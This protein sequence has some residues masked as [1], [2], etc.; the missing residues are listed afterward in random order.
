MN[1][2]YSTYHTLIGYRMFNRLFFPHH[3]R[4]SVSY[5]EAG[6][7]VRTFSRFRIP[8]TTPAARAQ[9]AAVQ[10]LP[11]CRRGRRAR[12]RKK[13]TKRFASRREKGRKARRVLGFPLRR[14][15]ASEHRTYIY[16]YICWYYISW[17]GVGWQRRCTTRRSL[18]ERDNR[19]TCRF[20]VLFLGGRHGWRSSYIICAGWRNLNSS[21][22]E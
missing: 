9:Q 11:G 20:L 1:T 22:G 21:Q 3:L 5:S 2:R 18:R 14:S 19:G 6:M 16:L 10:A 4:M 8:A 17:V 13:Q 7:N 12:W 15:H